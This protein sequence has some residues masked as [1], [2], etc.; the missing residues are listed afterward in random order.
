MD[1]F[2][3][4]LRLINKNTF[5]ASVDLRH[6][7]YSVPIALEHQTFLRFCWENRIVQFTCL[8]NGLASAPR[9]FTKIMKPVYARMRNLGYTNVGYIDDSLLCADTYKE[10]TENVYE[11]VSLMESLGFII[12]PEKSQLKPTKKI[13][14][15]GNTI[16]G[17]NKIGGQWTKK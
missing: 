14:F 17:P 3:T 9:Y 5:M 6:A 1:T 15:L 7:Y 16:Q 10:C 8:P 11:T 4:A 13:T 12:H 2:E